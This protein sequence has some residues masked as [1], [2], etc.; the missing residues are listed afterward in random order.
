MQNPENV[1]GI[2]SGRL[3]PKESDVLPNL[4]LSADKHYYFIP[5][6]DKTEDLRGPVFMY[7]IIGTTDAHISFRINMAYF[8]RVYPEYYKEYLKSLQEELDN[9]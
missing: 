5:E 4:I 8:S 9:K 2:P 1:Y 6:K 7:P 3:W